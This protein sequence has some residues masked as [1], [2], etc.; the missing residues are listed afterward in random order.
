MPITIAL[1]PNNVDASASNFVYGIATLTFTGSTSCVVLVRK[2][3]SARSRS[4][5]VSRVSS[6]GIPS[7]DAN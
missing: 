3:S 2:H 6:D 5:T 7:S 1:A 4:S